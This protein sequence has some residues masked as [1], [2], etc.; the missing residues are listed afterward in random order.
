MKHKD[1]N[2]VYV[3]LLC[4]MCWCL[5]A[6]AQESHTL[7][8]IEIVSRH[9]FSDIIPSQNLSGKQLENLNALSVADALRYFSGL[10][11]KDYG[12]DLTD[13]KPASG[14]VL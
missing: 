6:S 4:M 11:V 13:G 8:N 5:F 9:T 7:D 1:I 2:R 3:M 14:S 10:Q 12:G